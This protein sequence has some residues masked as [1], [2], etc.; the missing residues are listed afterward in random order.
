[1]KTLAANIFWCCLFPRLFSFL[2]PLLM[3][4]CVSWC[5]QAWQWQQYPSRIPH[6]T[7]AD[8]QLWNAVVHRNKCIIP[9][10]VGTKVYCTHRRRRWYATIRGNSKTSWIFINTSK[11][12]SGTRIVKF[13]I[14][15]NRNR[16]VSGP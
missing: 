2:T 8:T 16:V 14:K 13:L 15:S 7:V 4:V 1:M 10:N 12:Q 9:F 3:F 11:T 6:S 5:L